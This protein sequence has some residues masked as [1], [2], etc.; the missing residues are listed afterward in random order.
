MRQQT[1]CR[2]DGGNR[3]YPLALLRLTRN[4]R[5]SLQLL[6]CGS[7]TFPFKQCGHVRYGT[8]GRGKSDTYVRQQTKIKSDLVWC[9][10]TRL[11]QGQSSCLGARACWPRP[12]PSRG[13]CSWGLG[14]ALLLKFR[15]GFGDKIARRL[16]ELREP[17]VRQDAA[18]YDRLDRGPEHLA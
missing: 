5:L 6:G 12:R 17:L 8:P 18:L 14:I 10:G 1:G 13:W 11:G 4:R 3:A 15:A 7:M 9:K 16:A 2:G